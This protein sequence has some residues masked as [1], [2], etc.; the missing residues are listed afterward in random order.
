MTSSV[1]RYTFATDIPSEETEATLVL[2]LLAAESLHGEA[3][4]RLDVAH[5]LDPDRHACAIDA[6][7]DVGRD[8]NKLFTGFLRREFGEEAFK[9]ERLGDREGAPSTTP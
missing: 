3:Q 9:V 1:Y 2:A 4:V 6:G 5:H 7:T 8:L